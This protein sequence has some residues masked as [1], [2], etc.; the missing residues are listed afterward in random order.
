MC[1]YR[2]RIYRIPC[3]VCVRTYGHTP[4]ELGLSSGCWGLG[5]K[6]GGPGPRCELGVDAGETG[7]NCGF[8]VD[9]SDGV[10]GLLVRRP[11]R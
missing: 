2:V 5:C 8:G 4:V 10:R 11:T 9:E 7:F 1:V 3:T 6:L